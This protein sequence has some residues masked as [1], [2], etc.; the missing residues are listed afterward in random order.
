[1]TVCH[2]TGCG[3]RTRQIVPGCGTVGLIM[4]RP[5]VFGL[6]SDYPIPPDCRDAQ[7]CSTELLVTTN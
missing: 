1:M 4:R 2:E 6:D 3:A 7:L 5:L